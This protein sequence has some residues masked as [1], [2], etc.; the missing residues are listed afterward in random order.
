MQLYANQ[1]E[2][3]ITQQLP[4]EK[5]MCMCK[6]IVPVYNLQSIFY[7]SISDNT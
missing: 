6:V 2:K 4:T 3:H 5:N 1:A 7:L